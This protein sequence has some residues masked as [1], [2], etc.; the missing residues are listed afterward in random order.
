MAAI[1]VGSKITFNFEAAGGGAPTGWSET[2]YSASGDISLV[3][4]TAVPIYIKARAQLLGIGAF[5]QSVRVSQVPATR[6]TAVQFIQ[7]T[8]GQPPTLLQSPADDYDPTQVDLL[9]RVEDLLGHRRQLWI[10]GLP[11]SQTDTL[12][13]QGMSA[14][15]LNGPLM[16][17]YITAI[18][19]AQFGIRS[20]LTVGP[21][22]TFQW[23][24]VQTVQPVMIR[25]RKRGRPFELYH[26]RRLA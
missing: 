18:D 25:N 23:S 3:L 7:G 2:W 26:G 8:Q 12:K 14:A 4:K 21:P 9:L 6:I 15:F 13:Q 1:P 10:G 19:K 20:R 16:G 24:A 17:Q 22:P 5:I 11:D